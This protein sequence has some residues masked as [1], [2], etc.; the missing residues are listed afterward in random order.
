MYLPFKSIVGT[1][2]FS[3]KFLQ[4]MYGYNESLTLDSREIC[5]GWG[6]WFTLYLISAQWTTDRSLDRNLY[7]SMTAWMVE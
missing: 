3:S 5:T 1:T 7:P 6:F 2:T 4:S